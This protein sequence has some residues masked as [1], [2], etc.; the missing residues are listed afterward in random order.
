LS[1]KQGTATTLKEQAQIGGALVVA[2]P[3]RVQLRAGRSG[4]LG[5]AALDRSVDVLVGGGEHEPT[6]IELAGDDIE[7]VDHLVAFEIGDDAGAG[8][9]AHVG[10]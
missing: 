10:P 7:R 4:E 1:E 3:A 6:P 8:Q 2:A 5:D 9:P